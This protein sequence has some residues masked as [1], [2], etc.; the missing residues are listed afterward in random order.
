MSHTAVRGEGEH[1]IMEFIR[2]QKETNHYNS[3]ISHCL[4]GADADLIMLG[5]ATHEPNFTILREKF[6]PNRIKSCE[7]CGQIGHL[8]ND[9]TGEDETSDEEFESE[10]IEFL[11]IRL[12]ILREYLKQESERCNVRFDFERFIDDN[13][14]VYAS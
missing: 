9:C 5:L 6:K 3:S 7:L 2:K 14:R 12:N 10:E 4:Y 1:K 11:L 13:R 8:L